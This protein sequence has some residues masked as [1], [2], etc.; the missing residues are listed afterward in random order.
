MNFRLARPERVIDIMRVPTLSSIRVRNGRL[1]I[2]AATR[3]WTVERSPLVARRWALLHRAL[4]HVGYPQIRTRGTFG[5]SVAHADPA[6]EIPVA[7]TVLEA[8]LHLRSVRGTR[9]VSWRE[10]FQSEFVTAC[11]PDELLTCIE[12]PPLPAHTGVSFREYTP[13]KGDFAV[14][15]AAA[16]VTLDDYGRCTHGA[17]A[18]LACGPTPVRVEPVE[19]LLVGQPLTTALAAD[20]GEA[21]A[22]SLELADHTSMPV[23]YRRQVVRGLVRQAV[24][25]AFQSASSFR[26]DAD[27]Q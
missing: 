7:L 12:V 3:Q 16:T 1:L 9:I 5:G 18:L 25:E 13:R 26:T 10:F 11:A 21:A 15:G 4:V 2:G 23:S 8:S 27:G 14:A 20:A 19:T 24:L 22:S 6:A 17:L